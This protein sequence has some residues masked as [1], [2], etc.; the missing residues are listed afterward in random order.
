MNQAGR[1]ISKSFSQKIFSFTVECSWKICIS[2]VLH[3]VHI[4]KVQY[5]KIYVP[6]DY[7][8]FIND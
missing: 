6:N 7:F 1:A 2:Y 8:I 3:I 4:N 5:F